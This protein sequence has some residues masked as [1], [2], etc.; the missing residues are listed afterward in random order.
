[1]AKFIVLKNGMDYKVFNF[2]GNIARV[3]SGSTVDFQLETAGIEGDLFFIARTPSGYEIERRVR[4]LMFTINGV[5]AGDRTLL[6]EGDKVGFLDY[7][8]IVKY[9]QQEQPSPVSTPP[10]VPEPVAPK[11]IDQG[12]APA[13][14]I[15]ESKPEPTPTPEPPRPAPKGTARETM[16]ID[17]QSL[18]AQAQ[19]ARSTPPPESRDRSAAAP[20]RPEPP[21]ARPEQP[22]ASKKQKITPVYTLCVLTGQHKGRAF[23]ID[24]QEFVIGR[25]RALRDLV[26]DHDEH[27]QPEMAVSREHCAITSTDEGLYLTDKRSQLRTYINRKIIEP[28]QR[29]F[30]APEDIISIPAPTG[31]VFARLCF[32]GQENFAPMSFSGPIN[33][34][35]IAIMAVVIVILTIALY[36]LLR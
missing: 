1:M 36:L 23:E 13:V 31:E 19:Q 28:G 5:A 20:A 32:R 14:P 17:S 30:I 12:T 21:A 29:E 27:G 6:N 9:E 35:L 15:V 4:D 11:P 8:M 24:T 10:P 25:E 34:R 16:I 3:G 22:K 26:I 2:E 7:I 33:P 18:A